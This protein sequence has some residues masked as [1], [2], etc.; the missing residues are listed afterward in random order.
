MGSALASKVRDISQRL[1]LSQEDMGSIVGTSARTIARWS[2]GEAEP[3][4]SARDRLT[5]L[6]FVG[7]QVSR[8]L[9]PEAAN[10]WIFSPNELL[11]AD[12]PAERIRAGDFRSVLALIEALADGVVV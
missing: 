8:V 9:N 10:W 5:E 7:E 4:R 3:Q 1:Q 12:T 11:G 2:A 6:V